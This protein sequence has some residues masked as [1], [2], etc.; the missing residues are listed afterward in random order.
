MNVVDCFALLLVSKHLQPLSC[1]E[2]GV[3]CLLQRA[4]EV[5]GS[6]MDYTNGIFGI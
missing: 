3:V 2:S 1:A 4:H 5:E 6:E